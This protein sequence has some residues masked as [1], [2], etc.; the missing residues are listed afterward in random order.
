VVYFEEKLNAS[1][2]YRFVF[3]LLWV[4]IVLGITYTIPVYGSFYQNGSAG[5]IVGVGFILTFVVFIL[6][7]TRPF[8]TTLK[9]LK[10]R[11]VT[12]SNSSMWSIN[13][14]NIEK[15]SI[16]RD[17]LR[18]LSKDKQHSIIFVEIIPK[19]KTHSESR[20]KICDYHGFFSAIKELVGE[21]VLDIPD[22]IEL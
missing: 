15:I 4:F 9:V 20:I 18:L 10:N 5:A 12:I 22:Y 13:L 3:A 19:N 7:I 17:S 6:I 16:T 21:E 2:G 14:S 1:V 11:I 8:P